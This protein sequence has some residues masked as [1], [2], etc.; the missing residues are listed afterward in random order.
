MRLRSTG[1]GASALILLACATPK[2]SPPASSADP[3]PPSMEPAV[4]DPKPPTGP[5]LDPSDTLRQWLDENK[6]TAIQLPVVVESEVLGLGASWI[7]T[8]ADEPSP[9]AV[10]LFLDDSAMGVGVSDHLRN[11]CGNPP[12]R[13]VVWLQGYWGATFP[14][15][16]PMGGLGAL[17][18]EGASPFSVRKVVGKVGPDDER[19][20]RLVAE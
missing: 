9:E 3:T 8:T 1:A 4:S 5:A 7:G 11:L 10:R 12:V 20:V 13:C 15:S 14:I 2:P 18:G 6:G 17:G 19:V 16:G